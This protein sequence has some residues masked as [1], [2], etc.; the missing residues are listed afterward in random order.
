MSVCVSSNV[1]QF[2]VLAQA[3]IT[4]RQFQAAA[5]NSSPR[6]QENGPES[7]Q[8]QAAASNSSPTT[9]ENGPESGSSKQ[10]PLT[11]AQQ[12]RRADQRAVLCLFWKKTFV[13]QKTSSDYSTGG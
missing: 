3:I 6:T 13:S 1:P 9:Q 8:F 7:G 12:R 2:F 10:Q 5:S 11:A 4:Y